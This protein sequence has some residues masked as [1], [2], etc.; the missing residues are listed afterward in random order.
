MMDKRIPPERQR[1]LR[2]KAER[3]AKRYMKLDIILKARGARII[4]EA[5]KMI[6]HGVVMADK[7]AETRLEATHG[8]PNL[9]KIN[10]TELL[11]RQ[12]LEDL[13][14]IQA[15]NA[16]ILKTV[17]RINKTAGNI[18]QLRKT[19]P[20]FDFLDKEIALKT[21]RLGQFLSWLAEWK[22][23]NSQ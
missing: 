2:Q 15:R 9:K 10:D 19:A 12:Y 17:K 8:K 16:K 4:T 13:K 1:E 21:K 5:Q 11:V 23:K 7:A 22:R 20:S 18:E 14:G 6:Q 3:N